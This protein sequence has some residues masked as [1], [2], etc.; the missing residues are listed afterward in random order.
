M[1]KI[2]VRLQSPDAPE[3]S[4]AALPKVM[5]R[6]GTRYCRV[7]EAPDPQ[8]NIHALL[9][10]NEPDAWTVNLATNSARHFVDPG[11]TFNCHLPIF[12]DADAQSRND[13]TLR[14]LGLEFGGELAYFKAKGAT[15]R[16]GPVLQTKETTGYT[17][18]VGST[19][20]M[21]F[22]YGPSEFP[23]SVVRKRGDKLE[24]FWYSGYGRIP[25]DPKLFAKPE[26]IKIEDQK[27]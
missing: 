24:I 15:G 11:P 6:A 8:N 22:T 23:V 7:E 18:Q 20:L 4:F 14:I 9:V 2:E 21:L 5:Y 25:F 3:D 19:D 16:P 13:P 27:P 1:M 12:S 26:G 17:L 10:T